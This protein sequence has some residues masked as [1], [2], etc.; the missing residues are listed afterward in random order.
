MNSGLNVPSRSRRKADGF[1]RGADQRPGLVHCP[2]VFG[3]RF[4]VGDHI[5]AASASAD[6]RLL[7]RGYVL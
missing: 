4:A 3:F 6:D 5:A 1:F 2:L 7:C